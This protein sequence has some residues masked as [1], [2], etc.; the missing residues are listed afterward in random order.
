MKLKSIMIR[1]VYMEKANKISECNVIH[2]ILNFSKRT[3]HLNG[4]YSPVLHGY[5]NK[6][7]GI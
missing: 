6:R 1:I 3:K 4:N 7:K 2:D 5:M